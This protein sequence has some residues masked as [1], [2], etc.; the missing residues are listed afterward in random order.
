MFA[1]EAVLTWNLTL[2][3]LRTRPAKSET[4][5]ETN[6]ALEGIFTGHDEDGPRV[7]R[8][9]GTAAPNEPD[10]PTS[11]KILS[12]ADFVSLLRNSQELEETPRKPTKKWP[13]GKK[14][15]EPVRVRSC[16]TRQ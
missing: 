8:I 7:D 6:N 14:P 15:H 2:S 13:F 12:P 11:R 4:S 5:K 1:A 16:L 10:F 3:H 9:Q